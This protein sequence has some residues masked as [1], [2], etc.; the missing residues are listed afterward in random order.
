[1]NVEPDKNFHSDAALLLESLVVIV[2]ETRVEV[3]AL[4]QN[5][6]DRQTMLVF[7]PKKT[8]TIYGEVRYAQLAKTPSQPNQ[9]LE[10]IVPHQRKAVKVFQINKIR[11]LNYAEN[12]E[13]EFKIQSSLSG[14]NGHPNVM[15]LEAIYHDSAKYYAVMPLSTGG[16]LFELVA[17][18]DLNEDVI[19]ETFFG[20]VNGVCHIHSRGICHRDVSLENFVIETARS[21]IVPILIDFG[22]AY[23]LQPNLDKSQGSGD[24]SSIQYDTPFGKPN[25]ISPEFFL[26]SHLTRR[27]PEQAYFYDG[28]AQDLWALGV[29]LFMMAFKRRPWKIPYHKDPTY[30][31]IVENSDQSMGG[32]RGW[33]T[34]HGWVER[35]E[36]QDFVCG[37]RSLSFL[38]VDLLQKLLQQEPSRRIPAEQILQHPW[39]NRVESH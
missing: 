14:I 12:H 16:E 23:E 26:L 4:I 33:L 3:T 7:D 8:D 34:S 29:C 37:G 24:W 10:W 17:N 32:I 11:E 25:Y 18:Y 1:M 30:C 21:P 13:T 28:P 6:S 22:L 35:V 19:R 38:F 31:L 27:N 9:P 36:E 5:E 15:P 39:F 2:D 20:M